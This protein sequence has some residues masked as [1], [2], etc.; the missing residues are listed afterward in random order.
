MKPETSGNVCSW[1]FLVSKPACSWEHR[2]VFIYRDA[3]PLR[4]KGAQFLR[5]MFTYRI[6]NIS[7]VPSCSLFLEKS[8]DFGG[9]SFIAPTFTYSRLTFNNYFLLYQNIQSFYYFISSWIISIDY[10][11]DPVKSF[12][13]VKN[14]SKSI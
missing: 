12:R 13:S 5:S 7:F 11:S 3:K 14:V 10:L 8:S 1:F 2:M 9:H 6:K 4:L